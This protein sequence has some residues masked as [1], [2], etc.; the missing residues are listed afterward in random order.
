VPWSE[1]GGGGPRVVEGRVSE[2]YRMVVKE[3]GASLSTE[4]G[5]RR[6]KVDPSINLARASRPNHRMIGMGWSRAE[7]CPSFGDCPFLSLVLW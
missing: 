1:A 2:H 7:A 5:R 6:G 4:Q 3:R